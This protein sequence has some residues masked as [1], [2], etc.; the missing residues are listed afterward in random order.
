MRC[1][2]KHEYALGGFWRNRSGPRRNNSE[3]GCCRCCGNIAWGGKWILARH[4][5]FLTLRAAE[6]IFRAEK[7]KVVGIRIAIGAELP[8]F[9]FMERRLSSSVQITA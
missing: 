1:W 2:A 4:E 3:S 5:R 7:E 9:V 6:S 8:V